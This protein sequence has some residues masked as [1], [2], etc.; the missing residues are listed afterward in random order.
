MPIFKNWSESV[1]FNP[2]EIHAPATEADLIALVK[3]C[4]A[5][6]KQIRVVGSGHSFTRL[7]ET[8]KILV[9]L[10]KL[11]GL[12]SADKDK[13]QATVWAGTKIKALGELLA[14]VGMAQANMGD[15][16]VQS[17]AGA[18][19]TGTHGSGVTLG[20]IA[21][22]V[23]SLRLLTANGDIITCSETENREIFKMAQVSIGLLGIITQVTLQCDPAYTLDYQWYASPL[24][25]VLSNLDQ[26]KQNRNFEFF[27]IP[28]TDK[29]L[30]KVMNKTD[31][32]AQSKSVLRRFNDNIIENAVL[33]ILSVWARQFPSQSRRVAR[34]IASLISDG[35]DVTAS[36]D[37]FATV[38]LVKFQEMEYNIPAKHFVDCLRDIQACISEND[39]QV[40]FPIECRFVAP[41]DIPLSPAYQ[42]ESAY[43]AVHMYKGMPY[44]NYFDKV[45]TIFRNYEGRPHWGKMHTRTADE[46]RQLYACWDDFMQL[47]AQL[48]PNGM[49]VNAYLSDYVEQMETKSNQA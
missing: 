8:D 7:I 9:S 20:S 48:D 36:H 6:S 13:V 27:W 47:R 45:E 35:H 46:L 37:T 42:R 34:I 26:L 38:R 41:D 31:N 3:Q 15:I 17:V 2:S 40:H 29:T 5:D 39:I 11:S 14:D 28:H 30:V 10:D 49:F 22:Q 16:D 24:D 44:R 43:L 1:H 25:D 21:T 32:P 19:S 12:I 33:W 18:I 4:Y 23:V